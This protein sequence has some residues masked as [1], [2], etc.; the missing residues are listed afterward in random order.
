MGILQDLA[1]LGDRIDALLTLPPEERE[2]WL[3][4]LAV[5]NPA[6]AEQLRGL[7]AAGQAA[8]RAGFMGG[9]ADPALAASTARAGEALGAWT[10][11]E[12]IGEGG[13]GT[14]W[15]AQRNDGR[16]EGEAAIKLLRAGR[17]DSAMQAR[18]R[19]EGAI[20][21]KLHH[22]GISQLLDAG[23]TVDGQPYLVLELVRGARIDQ[24]CDERSLS[25]RQRVDL[26]LQVLDATAAAHQQLVIHRDLKPSNILVDAKGRVKLLDFGIA[27]LLPGA[28]TEQTALTREGAFALTPEYAAPEQFEGGA[29]SMATD[30]YALGVVLHEVLTGTHPS[31]LE[32]GASAM[33]YLKAATEEQRA[34]FGPH[35]QGLR[36]D[37]GKIVD[38]A[39]R[40]EPAAR[41][42]SVARFAE[43]L[44]AWLAHRPVSARPDALVY[45]AAKFIRRHRVGTA[46]ATV[47][48]L[49]VG[50]GVAGTVSQSQRAEAAASLAAEQRTG[51]LKAAAESE[52]QRQLA[53]NQTQRASAALNQATRAEEAARLAADNASAERQRANQQAHQAEDA[54]RQALA[55]RNTALRELRYAGSVSDF[56]SVLL[57]DAAG[58]PITTAELLGR[59]ERYARLQFKDDAAL[60]ARVQLVIASIL[61]TEGDLPR[62]KA[63]HLEA[64]E[65]AAQTTDL[66]LQARVACEF[67][68]VEAESGQADA[69]VARASRAAATLHASATSER[70]VLALCES[71]QAIAH[72]FRNDAPNSLRHAEAGLALLDPADQGFST[73]AFSLTDS[74]A[75]G[76]AGT[77]RLPEA[78]QVLKQLLADLQRLGR[79]R[80]A[81]AVVMHNNLG[82]LY[83]R[84]GQKVLSR[85]A[86]AQAVALGTELGG[87]HGASP[88][89]VSN[90]ARLQLDTGRTSDSLT[91]FEA[92][93]A[94]AKTSDN[95]LWQG[96]FQLFIAAPLAQTGEFARAEQA[97]LDGR[98]LLQASLPAGHSHLRLADEGEALLAHRQ[99][100]LERAQQAW[101]RALGAGLADTA[102]ASKVQAG[103]LAQY[104]RNEH[105]LG[106]RDEARRLVARA[107]AVARA[108]AGRGKFPHDSVL[109]AVL[110]A[111]GAL[112]QEDGDAAAAR[113][114][115]TEALAHLE[116]TVG[117]EAGNTLEARRRLAALHP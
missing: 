11:A 89:V 105:A 104:A 37:L 87:R 18:F 64:Q 73:L 117:P 110:L 17:I 115:L 32:R 66:A 45:R 44:R 39:L 107:V 34:R 85:D 62:A 15:R 27:R 12:V 55:E 82:R 38:K 40:A 58:K 98:R 36:G 106:R 70:A 25:T 46:L 99:N 61:S 71:A 21:A 23:V 50:A 59:A 33:Q 49:A 83:S 91:G 101:R 3:D 51:A 41:Y 28:D 96:Y 42:D 116:A 81:Q 93:L 92:A 2:H 43:D 56:M 63:L 13:M 10:L 53:E 100:Q 114:A 20:L 88:M 69:A 68:N 103:W 72:R 67:A 4:V 35:R 22:A 29:L 54:A 108:D 52:R 8:S 80:T 19:R 60:R 14:V 1:H 7:L 26:F 47:A 57:S 75:D 74:R 86:Y 65:A 77:Q 113:P 78:I 24:W 30:V 48:L 90:L 95:R 109:G 102:D 31:G 6:T 112:A 16:F 84:A 79:D 5:D 76:L 97:L 94:A 9:V 111:S